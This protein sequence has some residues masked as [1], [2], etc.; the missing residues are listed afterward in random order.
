MTDRLDLT[1]AAVRAYDRAA[2]APG[3]T[4]SATFGL[5]CFWAPDARFGAVDGVV[6]TR[7]GYAG[8]T[9]PAP[10][11]HD[12]GDHTE[13][14][15]VDYDPA[16]VDYADLLGVAFDAHDPRARSRSRQYRSVV[17]PPEGERGTVAAVLEAR[18]GD[19]DPDP[20]RVATAVE[21]LG[22]FTPAEDYHQNYRLRS[23]Q[24][25]VD[26]FDEAGYGDD[27]L[28]ESPA[29]A[30]LNGYAAGHEVGA[31]HELGLADDYTA[32]RR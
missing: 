3:E 20:T 4:R 14:V 23:R 18:F 5:G 29:A 24:R 26:A 17:F 6:R 30:T 32:P 27:A 16:R 19:P 22:A 1:P 2:P 28:R 31:D 8:G 10:T 7:V 13:V 21:S 15:Q 11:Y 25:L 12:L 9:T